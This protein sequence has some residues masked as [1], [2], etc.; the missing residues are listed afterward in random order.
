MAAGKRIGTGARA[1]ALRG[2]L[3]TANLGLVRE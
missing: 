3:K 1:I 2:N